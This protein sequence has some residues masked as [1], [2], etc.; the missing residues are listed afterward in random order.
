MNQRT[1]FSKR[2]R[3]LVNDEKAKNA[4]EKKPTLVTNYSSKKPTRTE[5]KEAQ[6]SLALLKQKMKSTIRQTTTLEDKAL[7]DNG[8]LENGYRTSGMTSY[9]ATT[10]QNLNSRAR[11]GQPN[12][13]KG[14]GMGI[15]DRNYKQPAQD[16]KPNSRQMHGQSKPTTKATSN[17]QSEFRA[18][19]GTK[20]GIGAEGYSVGKYID[21]SM[22]NTKQNAT[23]GTRQTKE[24]LKQT[25]KYNARGYSNMT[26]DD[27]YN[28]DI[29]QPTTYAT[30]QKS[31]AS[32]PD[33]RIQKKTTATT[34][35]MQRRPST[36]DPQK[37]YEDLPI[38]QAKSNFDIPSEPEED[39]VLV[40][41]P[42]GCGKTFR[43]DVV[44][45]HAKICKKVFQKKRK[46]FNVADHRQPEELKELKVN[47]GRKK[48]PQGKEPP[49][50]KA[51]EGAVPKWKLQSAMLRNGIRAAK[52][53]D[54]KNTKDAEVAQKY[55]D[56]QMV[57]CQFC[58]RTFNDQAAKRHI[59]FCEKKARENKLK[60]GP[61]K[62]PA[63]VKRR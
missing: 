8:R 26:Q 61:A 21:S 40:K 58:N 24:S 38:H 43:P 18:N 55:E 50:P 5:Q 3:M 48:K 11:M 52:G 28:D 7:Y 59:A 53:L 49:K 60:S 10:E 25:P 22:P 37:G 14:V 36:P 33:R 41:C 56:E 30:K 9:K 35:P 62:K 23:G 29:P 45:K 31:Q 63:A 39:I 19:G 15:G 4:L 27:S 44:K 2:G 57:R 13:T 47:N 42:E 1:D 32:V 46:A 51:K 17:Y 34:K 54:T 20:G 16:A 6:N 12:T